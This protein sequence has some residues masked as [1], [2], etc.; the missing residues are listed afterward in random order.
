MYRLINTLL[1]LFILLSAT[2]FGQTVHGIVKGESDD[3]PIPLP[4][5]NL[6]WSGTTYGTTTDGNGHFSL[7]AQEDVRRVLVISY[8]GYSNDTLHI[9]DP[10]QE[11]EVLLK[12][13]IELKTVE[14]VERT[15]STKFDT[16]KTLNVQVLNEKELKKA[17]CCDLSESF[18]TNASVD[19]AFT[20][21]VTGAK[22]IR[23]LGLDG[24]Y[25]QILF[26]NW[27]LIDGLSSAYGLNFVPGPWVK[28]INITKGAGSVVNGYSSISGQLNIDLLQPDEASKG[29]VN[30]YGN[31][32]GRYEANA[33]YSQLVGKKWSTMFLVHGNKMA[34]RN[35]N[36]KDEFL[37]MPLSERV[38]FMN[39]WKYYGENYRAQFGV[40]MLYDDRLGGQ[41]G[42]D[43][44]NRNEDIPLWGSEV[45]NEQ[46]E[47][48]AKNGFLFPNDPSKSIGLIL[49][50]RRH[51]LDSYFGERDYNAEQKSFYANLLYQM[52]LDEA[53]IH[54]L[55]A[56]VSYV[57]NDF[58]ETYL[59]SN[60]VR[61]ERVPGIFAEYAY[62]KN[63]ISLV[64]GIRGDDHNQF[65]FIVSP[66]LHFKYSP[67]PLTAIRLS[68]GKG[69]RNA[70][71][72]AEN[73]SLMASSRSF[74]ILDPLK[75]EEAMN[76]GLSVWHKFKWL[77]K[78]WFSSADVYHTRFM[79]QVVVD[80]EDPQKVQFYNLNGES[81]AT[82]I[83]LELGV[84][85]IKGLDFKV[86]YKKYISKTEY[87]N[88]L[89][90]VPLIPSDRTLINLAYITKNEKWLFD[91]TTNWIGSTR[92][93]DNSTNPEQYRTEERS[94]SYSVMNAQVTRVFKKLELYVGAENIFEYVQDPQITASDDPFGA[95]FDAS[96]IWGPV[97]GRVIYGGL[98][99]TI[100]NK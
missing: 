45:R 43:P 21:A 98:R 39:R 46:Q 95:Y 88:G 93:P 42:F 57:H 82:S 90:D 84:E 60:F 24:K 81:F 36:N 13:S 83:Q 68:A 7:E 96:N 11:V 97:N 28:S 51:V 10:S 76:F 26:E 71:I 100:E 56:G 29:Y 49:S 4:G 16:R 25:S 19:V 58:D 87:R 73:M 34:Q 91:L 63:N 85:I 6:Y 78:K 86:A 54:K 22:T 99:F 79:D 38:N 18:E 9:H 66:R 72:Y 44:N 5:A 67:K 74:Q 89:L 70:N 69:F 55:K 61:L 92:L 3:R 15:A 65:G 41:V 2:S 33:H 37:D 75:Q 8:V 94:P 40:K 23:M 48:F 62:T 14:I 77:D 17:A 80:R 35:D 64:A 31:S 50:A 12:R 52:L 47:I 20:D 32:M 30:L 53:E 27:P 1:L 59:D